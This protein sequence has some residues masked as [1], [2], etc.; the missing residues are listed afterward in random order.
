MVATNENQQNNTESSKQ[1]LSETRNIPQEQQNALLTEYQVAQQNAWKWDSAIWQSAAI[2]IS[3]SL[4]GFVVITQIPGSTPFRSLIVFI[5]GLSVILALIGWFAMVQRWEAY[6]QVL[7]YRLREIEQELGLWK[8]RYLAHLTLKKIEHGQGLLE[9]SENDKAKL[10]KLEQ[11]FPG[12][13][14]ISVI[15]LLRLIVIGLCV[16]WIIL[17]IVAVILPFI[18]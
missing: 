16:G 10:Q 15:S 12:F 18:Q 1:G 6:K 9:V 8:N 13:P 17:M 14:G 3:A 2:F 11:A 5:V 7:F 4:A